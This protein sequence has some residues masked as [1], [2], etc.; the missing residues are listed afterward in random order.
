MC[1]ITLKV[2]ATGGGIWYAPVNGAQHASRTRV[3]PDYP[4]HLRG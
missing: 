4:A 1:H 2:H 3:F